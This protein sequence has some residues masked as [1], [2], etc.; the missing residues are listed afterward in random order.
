MPDQP[1]ADRLSTHRTLGGAPR[2]ELEWLAAHGEIRRVASGEALAL[3]GEP[4]EGMFVLLSGHTSI[5][6]DKGAGPRKVMEWHGGDVTGLLPYSRLSRPPGPA[7]AEED[8]EVLFV[9]G[10]HFPEMIRECH[11]VTAILVHVMVD[12]AR[13]FTSSDLHVEKILSLGR[14]AAGLA[15]ELNNPASAVARSAATMRIDLAE[16]ESASQLLAVVGLSA[17]EIAAVENMRLTC[18]TFAPPAARSTLDR[19]DREDA[20][21]DWLDAHGIDTRIA[22]SLASSV[23]TIDQFDTLAAAV[24]RT[25]LDAAVRWIAAICAAR[26][27]SGEIETAAAR[28]HDLVAAVRGFT[29][30]DHA[31]TPKPVDIMKGL[32]DTFVVLRSKARA[33]SVTM[34][35]APAPDLPTI[36]GYGGELNQVW[37]NLIDNA[38]DAVT[39]G[40][41]IDVSARVERPFVVV[42]VID[43]GPGIPTAVQARVFE[44]FFTTKPVGEGTGLGLDIARRVISRH[45]GTL[46]FDT[47]PGR[48][49]FRVL[50]PVGKHT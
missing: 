7:R 25:K 38:L 9:S 48:T 33:K 24:V 21:A 46:E 3:A 35:L 16:V 17:D 40:G 50:L 31:T 41:Q 44:P 22:E 1:I 4:I 45:D 19:A 2:A 43:N 10:R 15:H 32:N 34:N 20:I 11:E 5:R 8:T 6:V 30:L 36:E 28:I 42:R 37:S 29:Y 47:R 49:E 18:A 39:T 14:L 12:R 23:V 26:R 27:L 13:A